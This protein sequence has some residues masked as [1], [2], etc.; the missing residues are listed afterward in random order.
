MGS[1]HEFRADPGLNRRDVL[2][3]LTA[4]GAG[5]AA[6]TA[7]DRAHAGTISGG[8]AINWPDPV[9]PQLDLSGAGPDPNDDV[10]DGG[11]VVVFVHGFFGESLVDGVDVFNGATQA[12]ALDIA[13]S[14]HNIQAPVVAGLW[15]ATTSWTPAKENA[16]TAGENL[17]TWVAQHHDVYDTITVFGHSLGSR[18]TLE[19]LQHLADGPSTLTS[20]GLLGPG[21]PAG[22]VC[23]EYAAGISDGV[24][25]GVY[26]Y[27]S[28]G[29][30]VVCTAYP[31]AELVF[32]GASV[33][34][35]GC[36]GAAC[37]GTP[38]GYVDVDTSGR[39]A[40]HCNF[41]KPSTMDFE[42]ESAV[43]AIVETQL[44]YLVPPFEGTVEISVVDGDG[45]PIEGVS[46][47]VIDT[48]TGD[49]VA[50]L[51]GDS[52]TDHT[53]DLPPGQYK[54]QIDTAI[55][56]SL[57]TAVTVDSGATARRTVTLVGLPP[58]VGDS[59]PRDLDGDGLYE[60]VR[61]DGTFDVYDVQT[62][63]EHLDSDAVQTHAP[64]YNFSGGPSDTVT[65]YDV[66][67]LFQRL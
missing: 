47:S 43:P 6:V 54:L 57:T 9:D 21:V 19:A 22:S 51:G 35:L 13:L 49:V 34:G 14:E 7:A 11:D 37:T 41:F 64:A 36:E 10:P 1:N 62:L 60:D 25:R 61:G 3:G 66:Q 38:P 32:G 20:A 39:V 56:D 31:L 42:G 50:T 2:R 27:H 24:D 63:F 46:I 40:G 18:V 67:A 48:E 30:T 45:D 58:V 33:D 12:T 55:G 44:D 4:A 59:P 26:A 5:T 17:A 16:D 65:I 8:C 53:V 52:G 23:E 15:S 28:T 29:D